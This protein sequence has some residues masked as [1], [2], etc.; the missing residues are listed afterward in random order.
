M[1]DNTKIC[2]ICGAEYPACSTQIKGVFRWKDVAC[3]P[4]HAAQ[5][6]EQVAAARGASKPENKPVAPAQNKPRTRSEQRRMALQQTED[7]EAK[8]DEVVVENVQAENGS[9]KEETVQ[10]EQ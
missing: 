2:K 8:K 1:A 10:V 5:Y 4:E 6:F 7:A 9:N 3:C